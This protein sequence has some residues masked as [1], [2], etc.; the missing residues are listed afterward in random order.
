[1]I[2]CSVKTELNGK[3]FTYHYGILVDDCDA[4]RI[5]PGRQRKIRRAERRGLTPACRM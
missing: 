1:M 2:E 5:L 4:G 3:S